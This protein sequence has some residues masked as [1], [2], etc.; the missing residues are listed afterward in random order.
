V[1]EVKPVYISNYTPHD[2]PQ[3][4]KGRNPRAAACPPG[5]ATVGVHA[6]EMPL[7]GY[8]FKRK[9]CPVDICRETYDSSVV[10]FSRIT[11]PRPAKLVRFWH[12]RYHS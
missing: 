7:F 8:G 11:A 10:N 9:R 6:E 3:K 1:V 5:Q 12:L 4:R 2:G